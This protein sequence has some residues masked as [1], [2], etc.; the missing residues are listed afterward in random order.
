MV[1]P[2]ILAKTKAGVLDGTST[3][4]EI[5][6]ALRIAFDTSTGA[7][8]KRVR[9][10]LKQ[11][12]YVIS[13]RSTYMRNWDQVSMCVPALPAACLARVVAVA[14]RSAAP[15]H[16]TQLAR[17]H[18]HCADPPPHLGAPIPRSSRFASTGAV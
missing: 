6:T 17:E 4:E 15:P 5:L 7:T 11:R 18:W 2:T 3:E 13:P 16:S 1:A 8:V 14:A 9:M 12:E 10:M